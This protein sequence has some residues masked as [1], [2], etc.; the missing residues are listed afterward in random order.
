MPPLSLSFFQFLAQLMVFMISIVSSIFC[1]HLGK[2]ELDAVTLAVSVIN[3][4]GISVGSGLASACDTLMSQSFGG[5]NLKRVGIILQRGILILLLCCFPCWAILINTE[6]LLLLVKQDPEVSRLAQV[7]VMIFIPALPMVLINVFDFQ[8]IILPQVITGFAA[9][10][11][12]VGMNAI[13]L[14]ALKLGVVGSAWANTTSQFTQATILFLYVRWKKMHVQTWGGWS[15]ECFQEWDVYIKLGFPS[16]IMLCIEWWTFEIGS[17]LAGLINVAELGAQAIIY[18]LC[19][20]AHVPLNSPHAFHCD[21][22]LCLVHFYPQVPLGFSVA[23]SVRVGNA[24]GAGNAEQARLSCIT[25]LLCAE[26]FAVLMGILLSTLKDVVAYIFTSDK[27]VILSLQC[28]SAFFLPQGTSGGILR[29]TG[30]QKIGAILN[31]IGYYG[32]GFPI[33]ISLM[34]A[35]NR[36]IIGLWT[37]LIVCV[38]FQTLFFLIFIWKIN[39]KK[40][41]EQVKTKLL[42]QLPVSPTTPHSNC[43]KHFFVPESEA[44]DAVVLP[45][46]IRPENQTNHLVMEESCL[47]TI[48]TV[49]AV[50]TVKELIFRRGIVLAVG[51]VILLAGILIRL[52]TGKG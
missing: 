15:S 4:T 5:K 14:Y 1:G 38:F 51:V 39:W 36:G 21:G 40:A 12:N 43:E 13:F 41:A 8:G 29:G 2:V 32:I 10:I 30:Q 45:D 11:I 49:G 17:F 7:Y 25:V 23:A 31:A 19:S 44:C 37:G 18:Q 46:V 50:L 27:Y 9:N 20:C 24:L 6:Q 33:G 28:N 52:L 16:M 47:Y 42:V 26:I 22:C 3:V 48:N 35:A 34:F